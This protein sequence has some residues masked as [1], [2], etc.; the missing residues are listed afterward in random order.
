MTKENVYDDQI[1]PLV[2]Q[3]VNICKEHNIALLLSTQLQDEDDETLYC[4]TILPGTADVSDEKFVQ[5]L[6]I[7]R[8]PSRSVMHMTTTH[9]NGSHTLTAII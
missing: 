3:I 6:N 4:T 5:A 8:P 7:I 2:H 1:S 9:A